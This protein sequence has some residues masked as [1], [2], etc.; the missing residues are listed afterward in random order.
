MKYNV[1][2]HAL[3]IFVFGNS[4]F[5]LIKYDKEIICDNIQIP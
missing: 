4:S 3:E 1:C 5:I 2:I